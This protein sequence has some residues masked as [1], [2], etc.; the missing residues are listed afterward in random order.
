MPFNY[1]ANPSHM[2]IENIDLTVSSISETS[3]AG[4]HKENK[5][6]HD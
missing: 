2:L 6:K 1:K 5:A 3:S 4:S